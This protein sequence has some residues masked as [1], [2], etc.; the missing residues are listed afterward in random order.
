MEKQGPPSERRPSYELVLLFPSLF[1][2]ALSRQR[3]FYALLLAR[4]EVKGVTFH[5]LDDVLLLDFAL[6][7]TQGIL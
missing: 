6:K 7:T 1:S 2:A 5:F 3:F 4:L